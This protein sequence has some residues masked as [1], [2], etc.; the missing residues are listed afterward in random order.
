MGDVLP[1]LLLRNSMRRI[2]YIALQQSVLNW[3]RPMH[4]LNEECN[5]VH[6]ASMVLRTAGTCNHRSEH[7]H[8]VLHHALVHQWYVCHMWDNW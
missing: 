3:M 4:Q 1:K 6:Q 7:S 8:H 5:V 2:C